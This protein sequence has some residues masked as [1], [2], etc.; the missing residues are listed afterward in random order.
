MRAMPNIIEPWPGPP[1]AVRLAADLVR[2]ANA[3]ADWRAP[4]ELYRQLIAMLPEL[5]PD[6]LLGAFAEA[7]AGLGPAYAGRYALLAAHALAVM[8]AV[9]GAERLDDGLALRLYHD[10]RFTRAGEPAGRR[11][12]PYQVVVETCRRLRDA[13]LVVG[14]LRGTSASVLLCGS[15]DYGAFYN[16]RTGSDLD[17]VVVGDAAALR[18]LADR[19]D[20]LPGVPAAEAAALARRARIFAGRYDDGQTVF[21][22]KLTLRAGEG[23]D[24]LLP[25]DGPIQRYP[26]SLHF[27]T[28]PL[29]RYVLVGSATR[30]TAEDAGPARTVRQYRATG[31]ARHDAH[32]T[33]AGRRWERAAVVE[34]AEAGV[35]R[36]TSVY[37]FDETDAYCLGFVQSLLLTVGP[38]PLYDGL[39]VRGELDAFR[40]KLRERLRVERAR[41]PFTVR[42]LSLA[43]VRQAV[44]GPHVIRALDA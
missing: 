26:L 11:P 31:T 9:E 2:A 35:L 27:L 22:H 12:P 14:L 39:G 5:P 17:I 6:D 23:P 28:R 4:R 43:H 30:L 44:L 38:A 33:L 15:V 25:A 32:R 19:A 16:V 8:A 10:E 42:R 29:L 21:S 20:R 7:V 34:P 1:P 36:T 41:Q 40:H 24:P 13:E 37:A 18:R 3:E